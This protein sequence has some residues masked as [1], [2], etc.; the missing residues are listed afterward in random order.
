MALG[1]LMLTGCGGTEN[2]S[3]TSSRTVTGVFVDGPAKG[4]KY[5]F[6]RYSGL[7]GS[8][9]TFTC[10][11]GQAGQ[12]KLGNII[13]GEAV[14]ASVITPVDLVK[15]RNPY[16]TADEA[17]ATALPI[18]QFMMSVGTIEGDGSLSIPSSVTTLAANQSANLLTA[19][20]AAL[21]SIAKAVTGNTSLNYV[22]P[23]TA[24]D[25]LLGS[26]ANIDQLKHAGEYVSS[27]WHDDTAAHLFVS[28]SGEISG[29]LVVSYGYAYMMTGFVSPSGAFSLSVKDPITQ[30]PISSTISTGSSNGTGT[31]TGTTY[32]GPSVPFQYVIERVT[33]ASN[34]YYGFFSCKLTNGDSS[35]AYCLF[36]IDATGKVYGFVTG[37]SLEN[38]TSRV[39][40]TG[41][42]NMTTGAIRL[43]SMPWERDSI[44]LTCTI[45]A[46]G[47]VNN[48]TWQSGS[49]SGTFYGAKLPIH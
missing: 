16:L 8:G 43:T 32:A 10:Q 29:Y 13:I 4:V 38:G 27:S 30:Q 3:T 19:D 33:P 11:P 44:T 31:L 49:Y 37:A 47:A 6:G 7:T 25:H 34:K 42:V 24:S 41:E 23:A 20:F 36:A 15:Y 26:L 17:K 28:P 46:D 22:D 1:A 40:L 35:P 14:C 48:G 5:V 39:G 45:G 12:F 9:G 18:V 21:Q 2:T